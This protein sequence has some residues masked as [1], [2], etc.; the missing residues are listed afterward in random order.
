M[1]DDARALSTSAN[2]FFAVAALLMLYGMVQYVIHLPIFP[3]REIQVTGDVEHVTREQVA[4]VVSEIRGNFFTVNLDQARAAFEKLPWVRK[5]N[6]RRQWPDCLEFAVEEHRPLAR[7]GSTAVVSSQAE[8]FEAAINTTLPIMQGPEGSA[9][10]VVAHYQ[11]FERVLEPL[12]RRIQQLTLSERRAWVLKL[13]DGM[14]LELGRDNLQ[15]RLAAFVA[16]YD[17]SVGRLPKR[18]VYVDL[19]YSNGFAVRTSGLT[20]NGKRE[21]G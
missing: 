21:R 17:Q 3:L 11:E 6:I 1:W 8:V 13:D 20:W 14:V 18:S 12:G 9:P 10:D 2:L 16:A 4:A 5:V 7:W 15:S 19:R